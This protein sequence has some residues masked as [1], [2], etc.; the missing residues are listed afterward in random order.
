M[1][2]DL[3]TVKIKAGN[4][5]N[6]EVSFHRDINTANGGPDGGNGGR[7]GSIIFKADKNLSTLSSFRY[8]KKFYA[9]RAEGQEKVVR[10]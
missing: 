1:F 4:G 5:G 6:G 3:A 9:P 8:K 7:G 10:I 2:V